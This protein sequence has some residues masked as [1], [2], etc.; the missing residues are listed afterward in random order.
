MRD[1]DCDIS[2]QP[3]VYTITLVR[4]LDARLRGY[5]YVQVYAYLCAYV[6]AYVYAYV[7]V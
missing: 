6:Y 4:F 3:L 5:G 1:F 2:R 7:H